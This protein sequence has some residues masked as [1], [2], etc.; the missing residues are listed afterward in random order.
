MS[1]TLLEVA[2]LILVLALALILTVYNRRQ[3]YALEYMARL[4]DDRAA[5][6][7]KDR[8]EL[9]ASQLSIDPLKWLESMVNP[10]L[11]APLTLAGTASR[12]IPEM[13]TA[14]LRSNDGRRLLVSTRV[15]ADLRRYDRT[16]RS[17]GSGKGAANRLSQYAA[18]S[19]LKNRWR[20]WSAA[21]T[22]ADSGDCFDLEAE[23]CGKS[24]CLDWGA[25]TRLWFYVLP[26]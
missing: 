20:V 3:A 6:E 25:P 5:R 15:L 18:C 4:E 12:V 9:K 22:M 10:W 21:R 17:R 7:I 8:R 26:A 11:D 19:L 23:A 1:S 13:K 14:E 2:T 24:L 16:I